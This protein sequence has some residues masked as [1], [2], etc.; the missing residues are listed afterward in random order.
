MLAG[1][2]VSAAGEV[3]DEHSKPPHSHMWLLAH[4]ARFAHSCVSSLRLEMLARDFCE[5]DLVLLE[6]VSEKAPAQ[7]PAGSVPAYASV[8]ASS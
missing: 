7:P 6:A 8:T 4:V 2:R 5:R 1:A 3:P